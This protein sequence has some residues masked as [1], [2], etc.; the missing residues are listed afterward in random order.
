MT[1]PQSH[2]TAVVLCCDRAY[3]PMAMFVVWQLAHHNPNRRFDLVISSPDAL[4]VPDWAKPLGLTMHRSGSLPEGLEVAKFFGRSA[5]L[6]RIMLARELGSRYR[7]IVYMDSD[8]FIE[9]GDINRLMEVDLGPYPIGAVL[10]APFFYRAVHLAKEYRLAGL[11]ALPYANTGVQLID[12]QAYA[13]QDLEQRS[14][15]I[16]RTLPHAIVMTDQSLTNLALKGKF[17]QLAPCWNWQIALRFP[18]ISLRYPVFLRHFI[19]GEKPDRSSS[20]R[21]DVRFNQAYR[22]FFTQH[23]PEF[24]QKLAPATAPVPLTLKE[25]GMVALEHIHARD[26]L[27]AVLARHP[28]PYRAVF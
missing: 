3:F 10:D 24:L 19:G 20:S 25:I 1:A 8:V 12:T 9:G 2:D 15:D 11:P 23:M 14:F 18:L 13:E 4:E 26:I 7:R 28:D 27:S 16:C 17:A 21:L 5:P 22:D 6:Y